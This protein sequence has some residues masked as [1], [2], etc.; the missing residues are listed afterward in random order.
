MQKSRKSYR[1]EGKSNSYI[2]CKQV[3]KVTMAM[4]SINTFGEIE[5]T[6]GVFKITFGVLLI[7]VEQRKASFPL[8]LYSLIRIFAS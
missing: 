4:K 8:V 7:K 5:N 2:M 1:D 6:L 3:A